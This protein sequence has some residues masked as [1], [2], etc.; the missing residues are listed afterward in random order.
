MPLVNSL[1]DQLNNPKN[2][3]TK[4]SSGSNMRSGPPRGPKEEIM[5]SWFHNDNATIK[6]LEKNLKTR[7]NHTIPMLFQKNSS[8]F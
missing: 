4:Q 1:T 5:N 6:S 3:T 8:E 2:S 7:E